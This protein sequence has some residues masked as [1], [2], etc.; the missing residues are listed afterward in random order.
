MTVPALGHVQ[1][2]FDVT[3]PVDAEPGDHTG[4]LVAESGPLT[5]GRLT[6]IRRIATRLYV[7]VPGRVVVGFRLGHLTHRVGSP[8]WPTHGKVVV[9]LTNTGNIRFAPSVM[10]NGGHAVGAGL[11]LARSAEPYVASVHVPW[12]GGR[13]HLRVVATA[14]GQRKTLTATFWVIPWLLLALLL[15]GAGVGVHVGRIVRAK[16]R[17]WRAEQR[18]MRQRLAELEVQVPAQRDAAEDDQL[19]GQ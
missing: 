18:A 2:A 13:V 3:V 15:A 16:V 12:W 9:S 1:V 11:V 10:V 8:L 7:T 4:V 5:N 19:V 6:V 14:D 17:A